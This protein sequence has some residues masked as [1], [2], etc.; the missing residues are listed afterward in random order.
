[1]ILM[2][3]L[4]PIIWNEPVRYHIKIRAQFPEG[5]RYVMEGDAYLEG[6]KSGY[7][8][9]NIPGIPERVKGYV[10]QPGRIK[11]EMKFLTLDDAVHVLNLLK[12]G[13][14]SLSTNAAFEA[15]TQS[16]GRG[17]KVSNDERPVLQ[18][19]QFANRSEFA[20]RRPRNTDGTFKPL[21][22]NL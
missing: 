10:Y 6:E 15:E 18:E 11:V 3:K 5:Q 17:K 7:I 8:D 20:K 19:A 1:M 21:V 22:A 13:R 12:S 9:F 2:P 14:F 4:E 16:Q